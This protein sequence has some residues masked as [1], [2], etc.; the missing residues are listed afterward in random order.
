MNPAE[1]HFNILAQGEFGGFALQRELA[2]SRGL[3]CATLTGL[4]ILLATLFTNRNVF[5][6]FVSAWDYYKNDVINYL[7]G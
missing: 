3:V 2:I 6:T 4:Y 1:Q 7:Y 5:T